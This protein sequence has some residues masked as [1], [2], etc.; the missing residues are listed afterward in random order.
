MI[1]KV[2]GQGHFDRGWNGKLALQRRDH[3]RFSCRPSPSLLQSRGNM[4]FHS[5][6]LPW[7]TARTKNRFLR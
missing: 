4:R 2:F 3:H 1:G 7:H 5:N 6:S